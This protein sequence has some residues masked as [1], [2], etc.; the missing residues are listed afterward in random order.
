VDEAIGKITY[1]GKDI[2]GLGT[3]GIPDIIKKWILFK[4]IFLAGLTGS[5][6]FFTVS[7]GN[8]EFKISK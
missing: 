4:S 2:S 8:R 3:S 5:I 7:P 6:G 1:Q